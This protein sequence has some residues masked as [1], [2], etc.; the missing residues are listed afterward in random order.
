MISRSVVSTAAAVIGLVFAAPAVLTAQENTIGAE[1]GF[2][3]ARDFTGFT[4]LGF[5]EAKSLVFF[6][7]GAVDVGFGGDD[8]GVEERDGN[9]VELASDQIVNDSRCVSLDGG[10]T[11]RGGFSFPVQE[12]DVQLGLGYRFAKSQSGVVGS[13]SLRWPRDAGWWGVTL[14]VGSDLI[15]ATAG[16][17][18]DLLREVGGR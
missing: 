12:K 18:F 9:C 1:A 4:A 8:S 14:E 7:R 17:G 13:A 10:L 16:I 6:A 11:I 2:V 15:R 5:F 3:D